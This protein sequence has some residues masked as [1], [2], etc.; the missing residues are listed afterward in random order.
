MFMGE[1]I[2]ARLTRLPE[3]ILVRA[4]E[5]R[6]VDALGRRERQ[7]AELLSDGLALKAVVMKLGLS[8]STVENHRD[9]IYRKLGVSSRP[10]LIAALRDAQLF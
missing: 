4:R 7:I 8:P 9:H 3:R 1:R 6:S 2:V 5:S 10:A